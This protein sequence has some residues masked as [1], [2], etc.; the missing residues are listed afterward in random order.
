MPAGAVS[1]GARS[2]PAA[3]GFTV[4][5]C[6]TGVEGE[7]PMRLTRGEADRDTYRRS[8]VP[9]E[10][11]VEGCHLLSPVGSPREIKV[12]GKRRGPQLGCS[13]DQEEPNSLRSTAVALS[14][15]TWPCEPCVR[16]P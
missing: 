11:L 3:P 1:G 2:P 9:R 10:C 14:S 16:S 8:A 7:R 13:Q 15:S 12:G 6:P 5:F 4:Y